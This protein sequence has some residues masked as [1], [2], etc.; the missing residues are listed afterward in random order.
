M[1]NANG[2]AAACAVYNV[3]K[4]YGGVQ[5]LIGVDFQVYP[6]QVHAIVG[7][8]GAGKS[9]LMKILAG[10]EQPDGG[11][12]YVAGK[13]VSFRNVNQANEHGVAIVFQEL[14]LFP[15]LDVLANMFVLQAPQRLG[16]INRAEMERRALP[17][18]K[19][20]GLEQMNLRQSV[21]QLPLGEQQLVEIAKALL[22]NSKVLILDEPN[23]ALNAAETERLFTIIR[24]LRDLGVAII[25]ISHR[26]EE[27]FQIAD[28]IT[29]MRNGDIVETF[30]AS[31]TTIPEVVA[32]MIGRQL[33][34]LYG[35]RIYTPLEGAPLHLEHVT[36]ADKLQ[37]VTFTVARGEIVGLAGLEGSGTNTVLE[38][39]F[40]LRQPDK[41][42]VT[43]PSSAHTPRTINA[44]VRS[45][46]A[47]IPSDRRND[48]LMLDQDIATN[49]A[50]VT[51]GVLGRLG[52]FLKPRT[53]KERAQTRSAKLHIKA[54]SV[55][56]PVKHLSGGNQQKVVLA[57]WLDADPAVV[58]LN[59][60][61]RGVDVG[62]KGEIYR[63][64]QSLADEGR[65][66]VFVSS[67]LPEYVHLCNRV[68][69]FYRGRMCGEF[70]RQD[71]NTHRLLEAINTGIV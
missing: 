19:E 68:L 11:E 66:V 59:D 13:R 12:V 6:G 44:A 29:V 35:E 45:D 64:I 50:Q 10:A 43:L 46:V 71:L 16:M 51:A 30:D 69:V 57:K 33:S 37:D 70:V 7:E 20:L 24:R 3:V 52:F 63:I 36:V 9:T 38:V 53:V 21:G 65:V 54:D 1:A 48:G 17:I 61:T 67:E 55:T 18:L 15:D 31:S 41:G 39:I 62:A 25:Y 40:G 23:S 58:L 8:N 47:L 49:V 2:L 27:V 14:N 34:E 4:N 5:A 28:L 42:Y 56:T 32:L 26:L 22:A 60:P